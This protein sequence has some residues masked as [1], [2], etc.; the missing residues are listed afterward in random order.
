MKLGVVGKSAKIRVVAGIGAKERIGT[1]EWIGEAVFEAV[2]AMGES[3]RGGA[4][5]AAASTLYF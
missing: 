1:V 3:A 2:T 4:E 5:V